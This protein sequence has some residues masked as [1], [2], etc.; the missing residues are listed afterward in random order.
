M[1]EKEGG[2]ENTRKEMDHF[3]ECLEECR[4]RDLGY[5]GH[6]FTWERGATS[7][8][9]VR[10]RL[11][12]YVATIPWCS[13]FPNFEVTHLARYKSDHCPIVLTAKNRSGKQRRRKKGFKFETCWLLD[14]ECEPLVRRAWGKGRVW[15]CSRVNSLINVEQGDWNEELIAEVFEERDVKCILAIPLSE[16]LPRDELIW[17]FSKDG[18]YSPKSASLLMEN[19]H[20]ID[21]GPWAFE[22][23]AHNRIGQCPWCNTHEESTQHALFECTRAREI[24]EACDCKMLLEDGADMS[25][26]DR[27]MQWK[28]YGEKARA[29]GGY[30]VWNIWWERNRKVSLNPKVWQPPPC[31]IVKLNVDASID[32]AGWV[33]FGVVARTHEGK[34]VF[35]ATR[36]NKARWTPE[37][38][39]AKA[40]VYAVKLGRHFGITKAMVES[41][42]LTII[43]RLSKGATHLT[44]LDTVLGDALQLSSSFAC[45]TWSHINREG[46]HVAHHLARIIPLHC[47][48]IWEDNV[49]PEVAHYLLMDSLSVD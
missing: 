47:E 9:K 3:R 11:D 43:S 40:L 14:E 44:E 30:I 12:R 36:R 31:D 48:K 28:K 19:V 20:R 42:C 23:K 45:M 46:N 4:L 8:S 21:P 10:E 2:A 5:S 26:C 27:F 35:A 37:V 18:D 32:E 17:A 13:R 1:A 34:V 16:R 33:G 25:L 49:P 15:R 29:L 24:W 38:A 7:R 39:E 6:M 22:S 41:D